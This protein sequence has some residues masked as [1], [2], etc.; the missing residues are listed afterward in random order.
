MRKTNKKASLP[1]NWRILQA[2]RR[3]TPVTKEQVFF[4]INEHRIHRRNLL[5]QRL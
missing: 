4:N 1:Q 5:Q 3:T 2:K